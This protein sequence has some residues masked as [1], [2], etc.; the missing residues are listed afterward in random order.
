M[1][2]RARTCVTGQL[3]QTDSLVLKLSCEFTQSLLSGLPHPFAL[4]LFEDDLYWT[5]WQTLS[6]NRADKF[7]R[8]GVEVVRSGLESPMDI[9]AMHRQRQPACK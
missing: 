7:G 1:Q 2:V 5:D 3:G 6:I 9:H 8:S 4:T